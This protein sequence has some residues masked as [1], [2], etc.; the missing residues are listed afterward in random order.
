MTSRAILVLCICLALAVIAC[1]HPN[2]VSPRV[3]QRLTKKG[4]GF[5]LVFGAVSTP[6][7]VLERPTIRFV[8]GGSRSVPERI[9]WSLQIASGGRFYAVLKAPP[10]VSRLD[11]FYAEVGT[12]DS[13][14]DKI[15]YVRLQPGKEPSAM[16]VGDILVTPAQNRSAKGQ[17]IETTTRDDFENALR[18]LKRLYPRFDGAIVK[19]PLLR[20]PLPAPTPPSRGILSSETKGD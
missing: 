16:Y 7:G 2:R 12:A 10:D 6:K 18:E 11:E 13:G 9:L 14:F 8:Y 1:A 4:E 15:L 19:A 5:L 3:L 17:K 20:H